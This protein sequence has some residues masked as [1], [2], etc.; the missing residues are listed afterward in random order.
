MLLQAES[1]AE[2]T[3]EREERSLYAV[4]RTQDTRKSENGLDCS[5]HETDHW[6]GLRA[7]LELGDVKTR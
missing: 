2:M 4:K 1:N 7:R 3:A 6:V 5:K